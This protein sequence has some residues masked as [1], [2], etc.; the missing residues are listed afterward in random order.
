[1]PFREFKARVEARLGT[2]LVQA[3]A[4]EAGEDWD[5]EIWIDAVEDTLA[6]GRFR[7]I[8]AVDEINAGLKRTILYLN[9][10][11]DI[12]VVAAELRRARLG[13]VEVLAPQVFAD[14]QA[15]RNLPGP[16]PAPHVENADTLVVAATHAFDEYQRIGAYICQPTRSFRTDVS[17]YLGFYAHRRIEPVFPKIVAFRPNVTL[18][19]ENIAELKTST[20]PIDRQVG[21][22]AEKALADAD[23][24]EHV[25]EAHQVVVL[26]EGFELP[27]PIRHN[28]GSAWLRG[29]R[30]TSSAAL[31]S[32]PT[33]TDELQALGG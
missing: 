25:G 31:K 18:S 12:P 30:Y 11:A 29:Q 27:H 9:R 5:N 23:G 32:A 15:R 17:K 8:V 1:M 6:A 2:N 13:D 24:G 21:E 14:E 33:T 3:M 19:P 20:D 10:H 28:G 26:Q 7:L 16:P 22:I 4:G